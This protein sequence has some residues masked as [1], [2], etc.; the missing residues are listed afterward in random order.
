M[1]RLISSI[2]LILIIVA[3]IFGLIHLLQ[4]NGFLDVESYFDEILGSINNGSINQPSSSVPPIIE[5][6]ELIIELEID[7]VI[8][9]G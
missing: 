8:F 1:K 6:L 3:I 7:N 5:D 2:L 9:G 4:M